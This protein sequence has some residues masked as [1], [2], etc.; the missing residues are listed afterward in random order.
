MFSTRSRLLAIAGGAIACLTAI[1]VGVSASSSAGR[2]TPVAYLLCGTF[3]PGA[4]N[5]SGNSSVDHPSGASAS[6]TATPIS[7]VPTGDA[8]DQSS[9]SNA[10]FQW[11]IQHDNVQTSQTNPQSERGTEHGLATVQSISTT[12]SVGFN[13]QITN[14]DLSTADQEGDA[15][16]DSDGRVSFYAS[17]FAGSY[18]GCGT[19]AVGNADTHGGA[20]VGQHFVGKYGTLVYQESDNDNDGSNCPLGGA[21]YCFEAVLVGQQN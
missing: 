15:C 1:S 16:S 9:N 17:G 14:F 2:P 10:M 12:Y 21:T 4:D 13:G 3:T 5:F 7:A 11:T 6:G 19:D 18:T 20:Q 8:C